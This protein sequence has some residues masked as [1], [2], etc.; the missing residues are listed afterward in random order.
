MKMVVIDLPPPVQQAQALTSA[1]KRKRCHLCPRGIDM[2]VRLACDRCKQPVCPSHSV[3]QVFATIA[4]RSSHK[5]F[6]ALFGYLV[7][8]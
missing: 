1:G 6:H 3:Q 2:K 7:S 4:S 8:E 5:I